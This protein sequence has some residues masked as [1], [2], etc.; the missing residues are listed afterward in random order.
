MFSFF[1]YIPPTAIC[2]SSDPWCPTYVKSVDF[3]SYDYENTDAGN[4]TDENGENVE[5]VPVPTMAERTCNAT[6]L[7]EISLLALNTARC[8]TINRCPKLLDNPTAPQTHIIP[9][10]FD[11]IEKLMMVCCPDE[12]VEGIVDSSRDCSS[13]RLPDVLLFPSIN[14]KTNAATCTT[15][16]KCS[17]MVYNPEAPQTFLQLCGFDETTRQLMVCCPDEMVKVIALKQKPRFINK[18]KPHRCQ[19]QTQLCSKWKANGGCD[20]DKHV[21]ISLEDPWNGLVESKLLFDFMQTACPATCDLCKD[22][23]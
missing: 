19:D 7:P 12:M 13:T 17:K 4:V 11:E 21:E 2:F 15:M 3:Y 20:L 9:C 6:A 10:G 14:N 1:R 23:E 22:Q 8:T 16:D 18:E 5:P